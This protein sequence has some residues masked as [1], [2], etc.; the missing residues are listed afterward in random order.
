MNDNLG[1]AF[2]TFARWKFDSSHKI[3]RD[4]FQ[5]LAVSMQPYESTVWTLTKRIEKKLDGNELRMLRSVWNKSWKQHSSKQQIYGH[6]PLIPQTI[7]VRVARLV[8]RCWRNKDEL[9]G[10]IF[11][12]TS[13][14]GHGT[15]GQTT[16]TC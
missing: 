13:A 5:A 3:K 10:N 2:Y 4:F 11:L 8:G 7:K 9:I 16:K 14:L 15:I 6:L 1:I 12:C